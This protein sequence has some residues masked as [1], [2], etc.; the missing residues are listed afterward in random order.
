MTDKNETVLVVDDNKEN[1]ELL[2]L[3]FEDDYTVKSVDSGQACLDVCLD[4]KPDILLLDVNMPNMDGY[5]VCR[6]LKKEPETALIPIIFVSALVSPED[7]IAGYEAGAEGYITKP[8]VEDVIKEIVLKALERH[9]QLVAMESR[10]KEAMDTAYQAMTSSAELGSIIQFL[11][12][13]FE[14]KSVEALAKGLLESLQQFGLNACANIRCG[15]QDV[16]FACE[17]NSIEAKVFSNFRDGDRV[18]DFGART[19]VN[20][21]H[22]SLLVKNMPLDKPEVYGRLKDHLIVLIGGSEARVSSLEI[23]FELE[24]ERKGGLEA[25]L[26][27]SYEELTEIRELIKQQETVTE[28]ALAALSSNVESLVFSLGLEEDQEKAIMRV[29]DEG[30]NEVRAIG[31]VTNRIEQSFNHFIGELEKLT[32]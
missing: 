31:E 17:P 2:S 20:G 18:L 28:Q 9:A 6:R 12:A 15:P 5:E 27:K 26:S 14:F 7:Q 32:R 23:E 30:N 3:I 22:I 29:L 16:F 10:N 19:L 25:I 21:K 1:R 8:F 4:T 13:S 24:A 11:Q